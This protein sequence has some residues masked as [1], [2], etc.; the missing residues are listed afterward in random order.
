MLTHAS[1]LLQGAVAYTG[2]R[3]ATTLTRGASELPEGGLRLDVVTGA[4]VYAGVMRSPASSYLRIRDVN[5]LAQHQYWL[6]G[7]TLPFATQ[8]VRR[9][10]W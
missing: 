9:L 5:T 6:F 2:P 8:S 3:N 4:H 7:A 10:P 1:H